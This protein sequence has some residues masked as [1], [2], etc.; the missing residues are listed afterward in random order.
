MQ[1][2]FTTGLDIKERLN[3]RSEKITESG[4]QI[5]TGAATKRG[6]G[7]LRTNKINSYVHRLSYQLHKGVIPDSLLVCHKCDIPSCINPDHLFLGTNLDNSRDMVSKGRGMRGESHTSAKLTPDDI[8]KIRNDSRI[9]R[10]IAS[11]FGVSI[12][13]ISE[14]QSKKSWKHL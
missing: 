10:L 5:W 4:C 2:Y 3:A 12:G 14:I 11:D 6:Y 8:L 13:R 7:I 9:D 1:P